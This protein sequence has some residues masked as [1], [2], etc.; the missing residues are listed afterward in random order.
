VLFGVVSFSAVETGG[1]EQAA[2]A[3]IPNRTVPKV[4]S[5]KSGLEFPANPG[6]Q[7]FFRAH[8][9]AEPLVPV[10]GDP[11]PDDHEALAAAL[12]GYSRRTS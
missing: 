6:P 2:V 4:D 7:D 5:A 12:V 3:T 1:A 8:F 10:G 9:F 11:G